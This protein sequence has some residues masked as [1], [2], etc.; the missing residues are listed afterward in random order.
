MTRDLRCGGVGLPL[1]M[2]CLILCVNMQAQAQ[3]PNPV[4]NTVF[5]SGGQAG[6]SVIVT[7]E[8]TG[9]E[10]LR[11]IHATIPQLTAKK[12]DAN[13]FRLDIPAGTP[14]GA[15]DIRAVGTH[16]MSSPRTFIVSNRAEASEVE[17]NETLDT[18]QEV[19]L[20]SVVNGRIEKPGDI[21]CFKF[22]AKAG[23][24][25]VLECFAERVDSKLR[26]V[27]EVH[28]A[29]GTRL[30]ANRG[31]A[32]IDPLVDFLVP[33]DGT[34]IAKV[35]DLSYLG[36]STHFYRL[37]IDTKPRVEFAVPCVVTRGKTTKV[38]LYG[39]NLSPREGTKPS[40]DLDSVE[41]EITPPELSAHA[42][43]PLRLRSTQ[44][45]VDGFAYH[46]PG[47]HAPV[48]IGV[49]EH[50]VIVAAADNHVADRA[51][52]IALPGEVCGQLTEGDERHWY[53][54]RA[55]RGEVLWLETFGTQLG[56][57]V[58][59]DVAVLDSTGNSEHL[60]L[61]G[62][63]ENLGGSRFPTAHADPA[64]RWVA[65]ADGRYLIQVRNLTGGLNRD[66][67]RV[68]RLRVQREEPDFHLAVVSRRTDQP[69]GLNLML[70]GRETLEV[71][72]VRHRGMVGPIRVTAENLPAGIQCPDI[73]IGPGQDRGVVVLSAGRDC[74]GFAGGLS[75]IGHADA[76]GA[77]I[78]R[79]AKGGTMI[80]AGQ[81]LPAGRLTQEIPLATSSSEAKLLLTA[82]PAE[83]VVDQESVLDVAIDLEQR[84]E[85]ATGP[86]HL[87][88]VG[89]PRVAGNSIATIAAG[90][91]KG[92]IS[93][94][95]PA[96]LPP[97]PY[98]FAV[99]AETTIP[100]AGAKGAKPT[101]VPVTVV[102]NPITV[103]V[104]PARIVLEVDPRTP[105][106]IARGKIIQLRFTAERKQ[107]FIGKI[108]TEL[109]APGGVVGLRGRG[110]TL[111]GQSDSGTLQV[112]AT[113]DAPL[114]RL[115]FLRLDAVGTVE[116]QPVY[117]AS[118]IVELEITE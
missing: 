21:D 9:L 3:L 117:R 109:V 61:T 13:R 14:V 104:R 18:A 66:P 37:D 79:P 91:T 90:K 107:G 77:K 62:N 63:L 84:F 58:D 41:T 26:A 98:T 93:F 81:S 27:L 42:S 106:K 55:R 94:A 80:W 108:H 70:G 12:L 78:I 113:E 38:K 23:Q 74:P 82:S 50:P 103:M 110:V 17:P 48:L 24:R 100:V 89:L 71:L 116:D 96:S 5:P 102:S 15:Y 10:G 36:S 29:D 8:G 76:S 33:A 60:K 114:G 49:T 47:S 54:L 51:Q 11:D 59:L 105:T 22:K 64:G 45:T 67:R 34:Y 44:M 30:A 52:E 28:D 4:L 43:I 95:F 65:P 87:M 111:V 40:L 53:A 83:A 56:S 101:Q 46:H 32:G 115:L 69:N 112:I 1:A 35:F 31:Y 68:Y 39:R 99:Q 86:I 88:G 20:D 57:P 19:T 92:W 25:V 72:A 6:T 97:G 2:G 16:G 73:W 85:G 75:L 118:R 7:L